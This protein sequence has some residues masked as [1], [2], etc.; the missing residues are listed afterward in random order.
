MLEGKKLRSREK[1]LIPITELFCSSQDQNP[2]DL[3][4]ESTP[5][6]AP[7]CQGPAA[8]GHLLMTV[9]MSPEDKQML[10]MTL[11]SLEAES[12]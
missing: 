12:Y 6:I 2:G 1:G 10:Q 11:L 8:A 4:P 5:A 9:I 7:A 3:G